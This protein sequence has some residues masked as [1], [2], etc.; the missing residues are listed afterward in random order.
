[1]L[2]WGLSPQPITPSSSR[3]SFKVLRLHPHPH[4][5][6]PPAAALARSAPGC[7]PDS[8]PR[9]GEGRG[10]YR[11]GGGTSV[12]RR[13]ETTGPGTPGLLLLVLHIRVLPEEDLETGRR[14]GEPGSALLSQQPRGWRSTCPPSPAP[15]QWRLPVVPRHRSAGL[16]PVPPQ[17][18]RPG[19]SRQHRQRQPRIQ[20]G[21][22]APKPALL[23]AFSDLAPHTHTLFPLELTPKP[24][25]THSAVTTGPWP[26]KD[27]QS[28]P[29]L[30]ISRTAG[31]RHKGAGGQ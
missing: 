7:T 25:E 29:T 16:A 30:T 18:S 3:C 19:S 2:T 6:R 23:S 4:P 27:A 1:V 12:H 14:S 26:S 17:A 24:A 11:T 13:A 8:D 10:T 20:Q 15:G 5:G 22:R 21:A 9:N 28:Q 31:Q